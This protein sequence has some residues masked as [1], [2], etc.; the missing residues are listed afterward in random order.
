LKQ[1]NL[2]VNPLFLIPHCLKVQF[3]HGFE[4]AI[5]IR[6]HIKKNKPEI[7]ESKMASLLSGGEWRVA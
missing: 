4:F 3:G 2:T 6:H 7:S 5:K 1:Q